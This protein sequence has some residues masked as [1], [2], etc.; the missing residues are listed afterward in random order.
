MTQEAE[1]AKNQVMDLF[2]SVVEKLPPLD[3]YELME[4]IQGDL[5]S[6]MDCVREE[7]P[8]DFE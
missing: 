2:N 5:E 8:E 4:E 1:A 7:H 6:R 3:Y